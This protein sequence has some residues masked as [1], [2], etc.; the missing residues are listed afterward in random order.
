MGKSY[1]KVKDLVTL[2]ET[3]TKRAI[4]SDENVYKVAHE[5]AE[6]ILQDLTNGKK[7][8]YN[9]WSGNL[10]RSYVVRITDRKHYYLFKTGLGVSAKPIVVESSLRLKNGKQ[11]ILQKAYY[12]R[13]RRKGHTTK[14]GRKSYIYHKR[15]VS[16]SVFAPS[17]GNADGRGRKVREYQ[18][19]FFSYG[20]RKEGLVRQLRPIENEIRLNPR[21]RH[22]Y[23]SNI[24]QGRSRKTMSILIGNYT[25]YRHSVET[26]GY[27]VIDP[28]ARKR[29]GKLV[30]DKA[31]EVFGEQI[32]KVCAD[33]NRGQL[34][35][36]KTG[37]FTK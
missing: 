14:F 12:F 21:E 24:P 1:T 37:R 36:L 29:Y 3:G 19:K 35:D 9:D 22:Q 23:I 18:N 34:R 26:H 20:E 25:P 10:R 27:Q 2:I 4:K 8:R 31:M 16:W 7:L 11:S 15:K 33:I 30:R 13:L 6:P 32:K 28:K 17:Q 5:I